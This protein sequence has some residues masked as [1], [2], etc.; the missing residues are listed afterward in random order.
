MGARTARTARSSTASAVPPRRHSL[1]RSATP[2][3]RPP[4]NAAGR[5]GGRVSGMSGNASARRPS[6]KHNDPCV[7]AAERSSVMNAGRRPRA[8]PGAVRRTATP[9]SASGA[10]GA[11]LSPTSWPGHSTTAPSATTNSGT[12]TRMRG[13]PS[14]SPAAGSCA[15]VPDPVRQ[16]SPGPRLRLGG[17]GPVAR[18]ACGQCRSGRAPCTALDVL[19]R[20]GGMSPEP[21]VHQFAV[22]GPALVGRHV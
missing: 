17:R 2:A 20:A 9:L 11:H 16:H 21:G 14:P 19:A 13:W 7:P 3:S 1:R 12:R 4:W 22:E 18:W 5:S 8:L 10:S 15:G 6:G